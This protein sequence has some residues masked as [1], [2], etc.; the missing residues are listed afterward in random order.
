L[1]TCAGPRLIKSGRIMAGL[2]AANMF[3]SMGA[4]LE[5]ERTWRTAVGCDQSGQHLWAVL[6]ARGKDGLAGATLEETAQTL[7]ELGAFDAMNLDGGSSTSIWS[8]RIGSELL[9]LFPLQLPIHH[10]LFL[11]KDLVISPFQE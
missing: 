2:S 6:L 1:A 4:G 3:A 7:L 11:R 9:T 10:A 8:N 5:K